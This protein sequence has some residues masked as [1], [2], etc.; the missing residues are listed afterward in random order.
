[1]TPSRRIPTQVVYAK[2]ASG[3]WKSV[4]VVTPIE[5][6]RDEIRKFSNKRLFFESL[7]QRNVVLID[8]DGMYPNPNNMR[9]ASSLKESIC[10]NFHLIDRV[11]E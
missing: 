6:W 9:R 8:D 2:D 3:R 4:P 7:Y 10:R 1:M 5:K 11:Y